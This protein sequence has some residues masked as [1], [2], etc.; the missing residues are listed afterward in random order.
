[1]HFRG[2]GINVELSRGVSALLYQIMGHVCDRFGGVARGGS[3]IDNLPS[4]M[5]L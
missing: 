1:M 4:G 2:A 5:S 3:T